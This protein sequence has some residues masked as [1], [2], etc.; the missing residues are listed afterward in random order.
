MA[1][2]H[3]QKAKQKEQKVPDVLTSLTPADAEDIHSELGRPWTDVHSCILAFQ[4]DNTANQIAAIDPKDIRVLLLLGAP[5]GE[6]GRLHSVLAEVAAR[7]GDDPFVVRSRA[8]EKLKDTAA[9]GGDYLTFISYVEFLLRRK[10]DA[11]LEWS[12]FRQSNSSMDT[13]LSFIGR[14]EQREDVD[15]ESAAK[16]VLDGL[17]PAKGEGGN[18]LQLDSE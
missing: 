8:I 3:K 5:S 11:D 7:Y 17:E 4:A 1:Q 6:L 14:F 2:K 10:Q 13:A 15:P 12:L 9:T 18:P 16:D